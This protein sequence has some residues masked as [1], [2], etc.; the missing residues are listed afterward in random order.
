MNALLSFFRPNITK[1]IMFAILMLIAIGGFAQSWVFSGKDQGLPKPPLYDFYSFMP[2]WGIWMMLLVPLFIPY[3]ILRMIG[4]D[5]LAG[6]GGIVWVIQIVYFY[7]M[8]CALSLLWN[9]MRANN[10]LK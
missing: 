10:T 1:G 2:L 4:L 5:L 7:T 9:R 3:N 8:A 6:H